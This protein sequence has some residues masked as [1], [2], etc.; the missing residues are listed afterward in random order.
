MTL[1][2]LLLSGRVK[3]RGRE[4]HSSCHAHPLSKKLKVLTITNTS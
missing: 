2:D 3:N 1:L 4:V